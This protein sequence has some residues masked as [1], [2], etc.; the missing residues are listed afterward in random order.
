MLAIKSDSITLALPMKFARSTFALI[1]LNVA[2]LAA[3]SYFLAQRFGHE[4]SEPRIQ[5]VT[6]Y[7]S[8]LKGAPKPAVIVTN[9]LAATN[10]F[11]WGQLESE[12]YR[13]YVARLRAIGCPEQT[14]RDI[15]IA[16]VDKLLAPKV[17]AASGRTN[18]VSYWQPL[19]EELWESAEQKE[20]M[21]QQ[22]A[23][24]FE[25]REV[26]RE[27]LGVDLV[28]E[29]LRIQG[30]AD[31]YGERLGF[32]PE[33][34][35]A[36]VRTLLDQFADQERTLLEQRI[37]DG[38]GTAAGGDELARLRQQ[39]N[40]AIAQLLTPE[41]REQYDLWF[42][43]TANAARDS[44][45]GMNASE[46]EFLRLYEL[47]RAFAAKHGE[48]FQSSAEAAQEFETAVQQALGENR[49]IDYRRAQDPDFRELARVATRFKL[50]PELAVQLYGY[51]QAVEEE[52][53]R[54]EAEPG[55]TPQQKSAAHDAITQETQR[56]F[57]EALGEKAFRHYIRRTSN[58]WVRGGPQRSAGGVASTADV[59]ACCK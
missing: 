21:R 30:Q 29:R 52:R 57:R 9:M 10:Q 56:A 8:V 34:K 20:A 3:L 46:E 45:T 47:R 43:P 26:V 2:W 50:A 40:A 48:A 7:V 16:D 24:D 51:K 17:L 18:A 11:E 42:S 27:L 54:V 31:Y 38:D 32:L 22:R 25:K 5:F 1:A 44:V 15:I 35:R 23:V 36:R 6:N 19:E 12:D 59:I 14:I 53:G 33:D 28:G 49:Y 4:P 13:D 41:E 55:L 58:P 39:K 37:E